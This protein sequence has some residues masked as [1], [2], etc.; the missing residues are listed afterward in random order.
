MKKFAKK[1]WLIVMCGLL[2]LGLAACGGD[3][4]TGQAEQEMSLMT[5]R[6]EYAADGS[7]RGTVVCG[8]NADGTMSTN[9]HYD[10]AG[11]LL[12]R[13]AYEYNGQGQ[14]VGTNALWQNGA[15]ATEVDTEYTYDEQGNVLALAE[16]RVDGDERRLQSKQLYEYDAQG[17]M[18]KHSNCG[19]D[20]EPFEI[21]ELTYNEAGDVLTSRTQCINA[22][23]DDNWYEEIYDG[24]GY[25][26]E[27]RFY[28]ANDRLTQKVEY[29][30]DADGR[31][32]KR[33]HI[34]DGG[35]TEWCEYEYDEQGNVLAEVFYI[36]GKLEDTTE[37]TYDEQGRKLG[38]R[39]IYHDGSLIGSQEY[40]RDDYGRL[41]RY[42]NLDADGSVLTDYAYEY[43]ATQVPANRVPDIQAAQKS[44]IQQ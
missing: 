43:L 4:Q 37:Y 7:G 13:T 2:A 8:Y 6:V 12:Y 9:S 18:L 23:S 28:D 26:V 33:T 20:G 44:L 36:S 15:R 42:K 11:E 29:Q 21:N 40:T 25:Q 22:P 39:F 10:A 16:Y 31:L 34:Y 5:K 32:L 3:V 38:Q 1:L 35:H 19:T 17:N 14:L 27:S 41:L 24:Q 30:R